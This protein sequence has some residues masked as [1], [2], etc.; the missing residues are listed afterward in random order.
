[1]IFL[2]SLGILDGLDNPLL[3]VLG[4]L[5]SLDDLDILGNLDNLGHPSKALGTQAIMCRHDLLGILCSLR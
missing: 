2:D 5:G 4:I 3:G 1:M